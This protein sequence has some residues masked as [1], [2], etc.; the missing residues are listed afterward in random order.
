LK[1]RILA[2]LD[3]AADAYTLQ[4]AILCSVL[5]LDPKAATE[6]L[7]DL[8]ID[9]SDDGDSRK[10]QLAWNG[11]CQNSSDRGSRGRARISEN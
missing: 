10:H 7:F 5:G 9:N 1:C 6:R 4:A 8:M 3:V 2:S 11:S